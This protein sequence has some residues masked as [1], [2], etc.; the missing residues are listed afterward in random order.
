MKYH[1][2][3][4]A[5]FY[6]ILLAVVLIAGLTYAVSSGNRG[7]TSF[8]SDEQAKVAAQEIIDYGNTVANAVQ[9]LLLRGCDVTELSFG[10][11]VYMTVDGTL[12]QPDGHNPN[13]PADGSCDVY[14]LT[15]GNI[16]PWKIPNYALYQWSP[17]PT[18]S[19]LGTIH[20]RRSALPGHGELLEE[21][22]FLQGVYIQNEIC[23]KINDLLGIENPSE[24]VP[25][26]SGNVATFNGFFFNT[27]SRT[28]DDGVLSGKIAFCAA[29]S[30]NFGFFAQILYIN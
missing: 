21:E 26:S 19:A 5:V 13:A 24:N 22:L 23:K 20:T 9:K 3:S 1:S 25:R 4:G 14:K 8:I 29:S 28:D 12:F 10:N 27:Q 2:Q 7:N 17:P 6:Y 30:V 11:N 18:N 16:S 15:G